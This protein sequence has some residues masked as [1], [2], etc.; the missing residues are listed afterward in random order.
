VKAVLSINHSQFLLPVEA[1]LKVMSLMQ[2]ATYRRKGG[3]E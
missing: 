1:A 3:A 2:K